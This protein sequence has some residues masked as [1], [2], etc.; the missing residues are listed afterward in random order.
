MSRNKGFKHS[1]V[2]K[3]KIRK[4]TIKQFDDG[5]PEETKKKISL[6]KKGKRNSK[7]TEFKKGNKP[8]AGF[9]KGMFPW[10]KGKKGFKHSEET[11]KKM[12]I[13]HQGNKSYRYIDGRSKFLSTRRYGDDWEAI[14]MLIYLRDKFTCQECGL[15]LSESINKFR[16]PLHIHHKVPFLVSFDNSLKNLITLCPSCHMK[17]EWRIIKN[18]S[19][20]GNGF[21]KVLI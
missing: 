5:M 14:R 11:K 6:A 2:T 3:D 13:S 8:I 21:T 19:P 20:L 17:E 7:K 15:K 18:L 10:N 9:K 4:K 16:Q 12:S 1:E